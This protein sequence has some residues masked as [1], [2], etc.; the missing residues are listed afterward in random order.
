MA[1]TVFANTAA[2]N[3][4]LGVLENA[5]VR[6]ARPTSG[7]ETFSRH[8]ADSNTVAAASGTVK[9]VYFTAEEAMTVASL[10]VV[11]GGT[12][13]TIPTLA[14][15]GLYSVAGNGDLT[16]IGIT[17]NDTALLTAANTEYTAALLASVAVTQ[18]Q[19][20]AH[21]MI[22]TATGQPTMAGMVRA[23]ALTGIGTRMY[24]QVSGQTDLPASISAG[25]V[26]NSNTMHYGLILP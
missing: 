17:A 11:T 5:Q 13:A 3:A 21:A 8:F 6:A 16:R 19:R 26:T 4:R 23:L 2:L 22:V 9:L 12:A 10:K 1:L 20:L 18:G 15:L 7:Q 24:G 14:K 25:S